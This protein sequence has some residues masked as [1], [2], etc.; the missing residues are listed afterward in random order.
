[1]ISTESTLNI[2]HFKEVVLIA[3]LLDDRKMLGNLCTMLLCKPE[4]GV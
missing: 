2:H 1:M 3:R 4:L